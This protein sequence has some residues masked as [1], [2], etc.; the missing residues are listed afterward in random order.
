[1][2]EKKREEREQTGS[3]SA[4]AGEKMRRAGTNRVHSAREEE[5]MRRAGTIEG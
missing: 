3:H 4:R 1:M 2:Q 5:K